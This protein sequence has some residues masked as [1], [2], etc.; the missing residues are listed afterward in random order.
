MKTILRS[1]TL[2]FLLVSLLVLTLGF[3]NVQKELLAFSKS[4]M[5]IETKVPMNQ[6]EL[7]EQITITINCWRKRYLK[8]S[9]NKIGNNLEAAEMFN[10]RPRNT[11]VSKEGRIF[12][13]LHPLGNEE[14]Q[15]VDIINGKPIPYASDNYQKYG[16]KTSDKKFDNKLGLIFHKNNNLWVSDLGFGLGKTRLWT[17]DINKNIVLKKK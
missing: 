2:S 17:F 14:I 13:T 15:L 16:K 11:L 5:D 9:V 4:K 7:N 12:A 6:H 8:K 3:K 10:V 1:L